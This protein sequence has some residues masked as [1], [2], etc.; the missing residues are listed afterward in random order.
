MGGGFGWTSR[1]FGYAADSLISVDIVTADGELRR[2]SD[3]ENADLFW[4]LR[5]GGGNFGA[6]TSFE[7]R[8]SQYGPRALCGLVVHPMAQARLVMDQ[9]RQ[10]TATA[11]DELCCLLILR[12]APAAPYI[13]PCSMPANR[14]AAV[15][16][17]N[18]T[19]SPNS[20]MV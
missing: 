8:A 5:G 7:F 10:I 2:A 6:V 12:H 14:L 16:T 15:I 3:R 11:P 1:K 9:Y 4:A 17:G 13:R 19:I 20:A 18:P